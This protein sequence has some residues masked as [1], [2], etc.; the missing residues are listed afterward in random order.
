MSATVTLL[1]RITCDN[2][3]CVVYVEELIREQPGRYEVGVYTRALLPQGWS[4]RGDRDYC[5]AHCRQEP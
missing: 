4:R 5:P 2:P 1:E 3:D